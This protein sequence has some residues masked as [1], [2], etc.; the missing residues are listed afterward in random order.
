MHQRERET[1]ER[2]SVEKVPATFM[3]FSVRRPVMRDDDAMKRGG[4][5]DEAGHECER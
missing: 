3:P 1:L 5:D 2:S 4:C